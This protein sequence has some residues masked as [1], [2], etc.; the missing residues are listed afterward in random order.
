MELPFNSNESKNSVVRK[1]CITS[2][3]NG[4]YFKGSFCIDGLHEIPFSQGI[5]FKVSI[6]GK[7]LH[8]MLVVTKSSW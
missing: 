2:F 8:D 7:R 1:Y 5:Y 4:M 3:T 6:H